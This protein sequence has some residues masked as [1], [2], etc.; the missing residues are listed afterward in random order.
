IETGKVI[1]IEGNRAVVLLSASEHC[2]TCPPKFG[3]RECRICMLDDEGQRTLTVDNDIGAKIGDEVEIFI[4]EGMISKLSF[5]VFILPIMTFLIGYLILWA[6]SR[7]EIVSAIAGGITFVLT[8]YALFIYE[9]KLNQIKKDTLPFISKI[10]SECL[11]VIV[12]GRNNENI[13]KGQ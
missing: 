8:F 10:L 13:N 7:S 1:K 9:K 11:N 2:D 3:R 6:L 4:S 5:L 12:E